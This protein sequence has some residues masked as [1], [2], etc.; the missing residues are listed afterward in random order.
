MDEIWTRVWEDLVTRT[1][2]PMWFRLYLQP[3]VA[4]VLGVRAGLASA[5]Q[6]ASA[7]RQRVL[8]PVHRRA[9]FQKTLR[10]IG[11]VF[12]VGNVLD[13]IFQI[14]ALGTFYPGEAVIVALIL[15]VLPYQLV[16]VLVTWIAKG[17]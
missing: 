16:R 9:V 4:S 2:G 11:K 17:R 14:V 13:A 15:V 6:P 1:T 8:D 12:V 10:D 7:G 3:L 5:R